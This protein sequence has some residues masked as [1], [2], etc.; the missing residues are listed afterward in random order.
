MTIVDVGFQ[1]HHSILTCPSFF[2]TQDSETSF[3]NYG[4]GTS[5]RSQCNTRESV[6]SFD[7]QG[8]HGA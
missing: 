1:D 4:R 8:T 7:T 3:L 2:I 6:D 5:Q